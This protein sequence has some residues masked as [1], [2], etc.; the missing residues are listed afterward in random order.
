VTRWALLAVVLLGCEP[1]PIE[2]IDAGVVEPRRCLDTPAD[3][4]FGV[5]ALANLTARRFQVHNPTTVTRYIELGTAAPPFRLA[6]AGRHKLGPNES[7]DVDVGVT[8]P[9]LRSALTR[10]RFVGGLD[11]EPTSFLLIAQSGGGVAL[12]PAQLDF[13]AVPLQATRALTLTVTNTRAAPAVI[14]T[15]RFEARGADAP[16]LWSVVETPLIIEPGGA[17]AL[18]VRTQARREGL[19]VRTL[20]LAGPGTSLSVQVSMFG[21]IATPVLE[22]V[23]PVPT[24]PW[25]PDA[26]E[27]S[28]VERRVR[29]RSVGPANLPES[30][31]VRVLDAGL[32]TLAGEPSEWCVGAWDAGCQPFEFAERAL[33]PGAVL[34]VP[35]RLMAHGAGAKSFVLELVTT[36]DGAPLRAQFQA[37][38]STPGPCE[39]SYGPP[40]LIARADDAGVVH[41]P[42]TLTASSAGPCEIDDL[43]AV[44]ETAIGFMGQPRGAEAG[45]LSTPGA[46]AA[47]TLAAGTSV[48]LDVQG[49]ERTPL[50]SLSGTLSLHPLRADGGV[51]RIPLEFQFR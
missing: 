36:P 40:T 22:A 48:T 31:F 12:N 13:G 1:R 8:L 26:P 27:A 35:V 14:D 21:G 45:V 50:S 20:S 30:G 4:D 29:L 51:V 11:C 10:V 2:F 49:R 46:Q 9:D 44:V 47:F 15:F 43:H 16:A 33:E 41:A 25:F 23:E 18:E 5:P 6:P 7:L 32:F 37:V 39:F 19:D 42:L 38:A 28:F 17:R 3:V 34:E 24:I